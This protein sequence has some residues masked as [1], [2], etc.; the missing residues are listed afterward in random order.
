MPWRKA[1]ALP[2]PRPRRNPL[3][4]E[5]FCALCLP[6]AAALALAAPALVCP[7]GAKNIAVVVD[8]SP[9]MSSIGVSGKTRLTLA[10][11]KLAALARE[12]PGAVFTLYMS[13]RARPLLEQAEGATAA[14]AVAMLAES[15]SSLARETLASAL[16]HGDASVIWL[17]DRPAPLSSPK[18]AEIIVGEPGVNFALLSARMISR[19]NAKALFV[20]VACFSDPG[21]IEAKKAS[22]SLQLRADGKLFAEREISLAANASAGLSFPLP[23]DFSCSRLDVKLTSLTYRD[24]LP[25]DD[26]AVLY[27][28]AE[29]EIGVDRNRFPCATLALETVAE[30][31]VTEQ[32]ARL[33]FADDEPDQLP[34]TGILLH[35]PERACCGIINLGAEARAA[36]ARLSDTPD[37]IDQAC[38]AGL[39]EFRLRPALLPEGARVLA[40]A[41]SGGEVVPLAAVWEWRG[42]KVAW[43]GAAPEQWQL[44][45]A[46]P[47]MIAALTE[48]LLPPAPRLPGQ[49]ES[50]NRLK[51][52]PAVGT[53]PV[54]TAA[55]EPQRYRLSQGL[56]LLA[57]L[58]GATLALKEWKRCAGGAK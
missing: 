17:S 28:F 24:S 42:K 56:A 35:V 25:L 8:V 29:R 47:L 33:L 16:A 6:L 13:S 46:Y 2:R 53:P 9:G 38:V 40:A 36:S 41:E 21:I 11:E 19:N 32:P 3:D 23:P 1:L 20:A 45:P 50:D 44:H 4:L 34:E 10:A 54:L 55:A 14:Q 18:V 39:S 30:M 31:T 52:Q 48:K 49:E 27:P 26:S 22:L 12:M 5:T 15:D 43:L 37:G 51:V 58:C 7:G 57:A